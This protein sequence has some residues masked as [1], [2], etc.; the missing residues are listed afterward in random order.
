MATKITTKLAIAQGTEI[1]GNNITKHRSQPSNQTVT[2]YRDNPPHTKILIDDRTLTSSCKKLYGERPPQKLT[3]YKGPENLYQPLSKTHTISLLNDDN[4]E[5][6]KNI[7]KELKI[8]LYNNRH[9]PMKKKKELEK[10][11]LKY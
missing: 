9:M 2:I 1:I 6:I 8:L 7:K 11:Q 10:L 4:N 5:S 3:F